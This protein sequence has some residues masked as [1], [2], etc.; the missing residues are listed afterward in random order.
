[1]FLGEKYATCL[2]SSRSTISR[3]SFKKSSCSISNYRV[4][5]TALLPSEVQFQI[6]DVPLSCFNIV[7]FF[8]F[9]YK[10][11][12]KQQRNLFLQILGESIGEVKRVAD[13]HERKSEM[14]KNA[15]AF[16]ALPGETQVNYLS[17]SETSQT[18]N[19]QTRRWLW[20]HGGAS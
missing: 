12:A 4:I 18:Y 5:P 16:I 3:S 8:Y 13:M 6:Y 17:T 19:P 9:G 2:I 10:K 7:L 1:M 14:A 11:T 20:N 15:D